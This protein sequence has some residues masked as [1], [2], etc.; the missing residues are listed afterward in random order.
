MTS[1]RTLPAPAPHPAAPGPVSVL[2]GDADARRTAVVL[3]PVMPHWDSGAFIEQVAG[4]FLGTGHRVLVH[5][6][7][8]LLR[9]GDDLARLTERWADVLRRGGPVDVLVGNALGGAV[10]QGLLDRPWTH[11]SDVVVLSGPTVA[12]HELNTKLESIARAVDEQGLAEAVRLKDE[13]VL[14]TARPAGPPAPYDGTAPDTARAAFRLAAGMRLLHDVDLADRVRAFPGRLLH[15]YGAESRL[16]RRA[17]LAAAA[18]HRCVEVPD[19]GMRPHSDRPELTRA[20]LTR[21]L[22]EE[23]T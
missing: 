9:E 1:P 2:L 18:H 17:H 19:A 11:G 6:T 4:A 12:D 22:E 23:G 8:S 5:D 21:F 16:V 15:V 13:L 7:V 3:S 10:V 14:G 20:L